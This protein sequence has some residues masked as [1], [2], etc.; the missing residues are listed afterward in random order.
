MGKCIPESE[1]IE[2]RGEIIQILVEHIIKLKRSK[3]RREMGDREI[4]LGTKFKCFERRWEEIH[5]L[6]K[7]ITIYF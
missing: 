6:L 7:S 3:G 2:R 5:R 4:K 1:G